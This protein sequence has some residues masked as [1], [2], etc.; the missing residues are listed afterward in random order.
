VPPGVRQYFVPVAE[1][2]PKN[3]KTVY[4]PMILGVAQVRFLDSKTRIDTTKD[5]AFLTSITNDPVPVD[6]NNSKEANV[7][8]SELGNTA[9]EG[10]PFADLPSAALVARNYSSWERDFSDWLF[11]TQKLPLLKSENLN[12]FSKPEET[13]RDFRI[14]LQQIAREQRDQQVEK[15]RRKYSSDFARLD[16]R[17]RRA[18]ATF[19]KHEAEAKGQ[20]YQ[21]AVSFGAT[22]LGSFLGRRTSGS[23]TRTAREIGRS[24]K[25]S[26]DI[27]GAEANLKALQQERANL[28]TQF[29]SEV[30]VLETKTNPLTENLTTVSITPSKTNLSIRLVTLVWT[31]V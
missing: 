24:M 23:A 5:V 18:Q 28:E 19:E 31:A 2:E 13:D 9:L 21:A 15:L 8:V 11:R 25:E 10:V 1:N 27:A 17:I 3:A 16:E 6:W 20:K 29:Q 26:K 22:L 30:N 4:Q 14:R 12:E 7:K